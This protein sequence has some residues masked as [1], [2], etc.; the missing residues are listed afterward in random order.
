MIV[1]LR[2]IPFLSSVFIF[3]ALEVLFV[4]HHLFWS[5][6]PFLVCL[7]VMAPAQLFEWRTERKEFWRVVAFTPTLILSSVFLLLFVST[8]FYAHLL[9]VFT[10]LLFGW[11]LENLFLFLHQPRQY[12]PYALENISSYINVLVAFFFFSALFASRIFLSFR[13]PHIII[14]GLVGA[15]L[16][17]FFMFVWNKMSIRRSWYIFLIHGL[18][19]LELLI[20]ASLLPTSFF[21]AGLLLTIPYYIMLS[22]VRHTSRGS[23]DLKVLRR[24]ALIGLST[25]TVTLITAPWS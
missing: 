2:F 15:V 22:L 14:L 16:L 6:L 1:L 11:F 5:I 3:I 9:M 23:L 12:Q 4:Q 7:S 25:F 24:Y 19:M 10:A 18:V 8:A 17:S 21:V 20:G 13:L